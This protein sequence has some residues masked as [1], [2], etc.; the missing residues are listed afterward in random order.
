[1][2]LIKNDKRTIN[3]WCMYDWANS[4]FALTI[5]SAIFPIYYGNMTRGA[6]GSDVVSFFGLEIVNTVLFTYAISCTFLLLMFLSPVLSALADY[7][8]RKKIF[9]QIFCYLGATGC[10]LL[11]GFT[12]GKV[13]WG[14]LSFCLGLVGFSGS[15]MFYNSFLPDIATEDRMDAISARGF[16]MGYI[17]SVI[18]LIV[19]LAMIMMPDSLGISAGMA[20]RI[21][22]LS[23]G[24]WWAGWAQIPFHVLPS[25]SHKRIGNPE[26]HWL[27]AGFKELN[28]TWQSAKANRQM[29]WF[30]PAFFLFNMG[31]QTIM[32]VAPLFGEKVLRIPTEG[33]IATILLLQLLAILGAFLT[34]R[35][36]AKVGNKLTLASLL[37]SWMI[38]CFSAYHTQTATQFYCLAAGVG[39]IMGGTQS[40]SRSTYAKYIPEDSPDTASYFS[41]YDVTEKASIVVGT[42]SYGLVEQLTGTMRNSVLALI[43]YFL[44][45]LL[46]LTRLKK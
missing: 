27:Q 32:L 39:L 46:V 2:I 15:I 42:F 8:G 5:V 14:I 44:L 37:I 1:M 45:G 28:K 34:S 17:G 18:L 20:T 24:L 12:E 21:S 26:G 40:L 13:E 10:A 3:A 6:N 25:K 35:M 4:A 30:L 16:S 19:N 9:M 22:F 36:S 31:V 38:I 7:S 11:F 23:V 33:L 29:R 41:F 43:L